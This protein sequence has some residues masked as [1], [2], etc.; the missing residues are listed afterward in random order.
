MNRNALRCSVLRRSVPH[1]RGDETAYYEGK[2]S[3]YVCSPQAWDELHA[4]G[5]ISGLGGN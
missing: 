5:V 1:K 3:E 4:T 2:F